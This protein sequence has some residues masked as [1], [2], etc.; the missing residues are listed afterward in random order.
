MSTEEGIDDNRDY[1]AF[2]DSTYIR[3]WDLPPARNVTFVVDHTEQHTIKGEG[4]KEDKRP[5]VFFKG[6]NG[7]VLK[8][9]LVLNKGMGKIVAAL[10][11][12]KMSAWRGRELTIYATT[13]VAFG[14]THDVVRIRPSVQKSTKPRGAPGQA[15]PPSLPAP[16]DS[17]PD[18][19][20]EDAHDYQE[21]TR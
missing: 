4:N 14:E 9:G 15:P 10:Y 7:N 11:G 17:V 13:C 18:A 8:K 6:K 19:E 3:A 16:H 1:R 20:F 12:K 5:V 2:Y 21:S